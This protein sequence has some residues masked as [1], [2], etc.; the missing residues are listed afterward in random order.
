MSVPLWDED[1]RF[2]QNKV[3]GKSLFRLIRR[4]TLACNCRGCSGFSAS[5]GTGGGGA[6]RRS[7]WTMAGSQSS[8]ESKTTPMSTFSSSAD[9]PQ[10][11]RYSQAKHTHLQSFPAL[12][13]N[14]QTAAVTFEFCATPEELPS[15]KRGIAALPNLRA[16][17]DIF[18]VDCRARWQ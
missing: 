3:R 5:T 10:L 6:T 1:T 11:P 7:W 15:Q 13:S 12:S 17:S 14:R 8:W 9:Q 2:S 18:S 16:A 4:L